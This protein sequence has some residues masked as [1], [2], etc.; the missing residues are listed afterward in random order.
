[1]SFRIYQKGQR[2]NLPDLVVDSKITDPSLYIPSEG[3]ID[4]VNVAITLGKPLL[5]TGEPGTGKTQLA[6]HLAWQFHLEKLFYVF[7]AK[8]T[9]TV[10]DLFYTYDALGHFHYNQNNSIV[11]NPKD[12]EQRF[13][14]YNAL[15]EAVRKRERCI[16]LIDEI[17]KAPRDLPNDLLVEIE[18]FKFDVPEIGESYKCEPSK[19]P[20]IIITSNSENSL[21]DAF[22]RRVVFYHISFPSSGILLEILESKFRDGKIANFEILIKHFE[23][24]RTELNLIKKPSTAE[25]IYWVQ[26]LKTMSFNEEKLKHLEKLK[27]SDKLNLESSY[28]VL[29]KNQTDFETLL[30]FLNSTP[31]NYFTLF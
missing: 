19:K 29:A 26:L 4:A 2:R 25:L 23:Y 18:N 27:D 7:V 20:I 8:T 1:M 14:R 12:I 5:L 21:P 17:D 22:L 3:L 28:S 30:N 31:E 24:I 9:S 6:S 13:I 16:V 11:L 10:K 15:G